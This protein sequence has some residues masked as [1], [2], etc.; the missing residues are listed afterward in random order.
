MGI[1]PE[2]TERSKS[3][4]ANWKDSQ[5]HVLMCMRGAP[6]CYRATLRHFHC[7][8]LTVCLATAPRTKCHS[9]GVSGQEQARHAGH[10]R[11]GILEL[12]GTFTEACG[13]T[14][15]L[16]LAVMRSARI[17]QAQWVPLP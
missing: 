11:L 1:M 2:Y 14:L 9:T 10:T 6:R 17:P 16:I 15:C 7:L 4:C 5:A 3:Y 8:P 12:L 13:E